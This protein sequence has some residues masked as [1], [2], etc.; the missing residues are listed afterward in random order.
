MVSFVLGIQPSYI[1]PPHELRESGGFERD[2]TISVIGLPAM[3][4]ATSD[5]SSCDER[6][7]HIKR[8]INKYT[9]CCTLLDN[10]QSAHYHLL[11]AK[12]QAR[13]VFWVDIPMPEKLD[14]NIQAQV[15]L[16]H[17]IADYKAHIVREM[18]LASAGCRL[19]GE[20][21]HRETAYVLCGGK[22]TAPGCALHGSPKVPSGD[23]TDMHAGPT[24]DVL[25]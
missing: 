13:E 19:F 17:M 9:A 16:L 10:L 5:A 25:Q 7:L 6:L 23:T 21:K 8:V 4:C 15:T 3:A 1:P 12:Q 14:E 18:L 11:K 2:Y 22:G 20:L 24:P